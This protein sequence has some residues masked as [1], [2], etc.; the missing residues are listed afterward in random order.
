FLIPP[1]RPFG[2]PMN[3]AVTNLSSSP[4]AIRILGRE[5]RHGG[6]DVVHVH[7]PNVPV[8][9]W[10]AAEAAR[11]P[12]VGTFHTSSTNWLTN[13]I[14]ANVIGARRIYSQLNARIAVS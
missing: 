8:I 2:V 3:G 10:F 5:L 1:G 6:Y 4:E 14:A 9:S 11:V 12:S 7:E 13:S